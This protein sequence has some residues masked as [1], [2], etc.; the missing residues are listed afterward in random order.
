MSH[1]LNFSDLSV[2]ELPVQV[3]ENSYTL[4]EANEATAVKW[5]N[6]TMAAARFRDG[7]ISGFS[8]IAD[9]EP[10]LVSLCLFDKDGKNV[11]ID[12]VKE[13]PA[14]IVK[15]MF[16]N[17]KEIS[18]LGETEDTVKELEEKLKKAKEV[19]EAAKNDSEGMEN[20]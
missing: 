4:K 19:E 17:A 6:A 11:P 2:I 15:A 8:G 16:E 3:G 12:T 10:L 20:S 14:R 9:S 1:N 5:R 7:N 13:W 18:E